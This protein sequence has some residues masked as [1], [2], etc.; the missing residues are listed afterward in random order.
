MPLW[1]RR[2]QIAP[3][4]PPPWF[5][6][7]PSLHPLALQVLYNR[8]MTAPETIQAFLAEDAALGNPLR[9]AGM[10]EAVFLI[11][12]AVMHGKPIAVYGDYDADGVTA[13]AILVQTLRTL[14]ADVRPYIP[15]RVEEGYGLNV[16]ALRALAEAGTR[17]LITVDCGIRSLEEVALARRLGLQVVITDHHH[18]G[19]ALPA[20]DVVLNPRRPDCPYPFKDLAGAGVAFKLAQA[21][22]RVNR[23]TPL[24][25]TQRDLREEELLDLA[26]LGTI[27]D[28]VPL[29]GENH[30]LARQGLR[31]INEGRRPGLVA[32]MQI[33]NVQPGKVTASTIGFTLAPR[34][35][36]AGRIGEASLAFD[37]LVAPDL[38]SALPLAQQLES[39]NRERQE[40]TTQVQEATRR[41]VLE[42]GDDPPLFFA[43]ADNFPS[44]IIGL[45]AGRLAEEFYR[46][47]VVV[48]RGEPLSKGSARSIPEFHI[49]EALDSMAELLE[50]YGGHAAAAGFTVRTA[51]LPELQAR[52]T[53]LAREQLAGVT[54]TPT[55]QIDAELPL[56]D[57]SWEL[58]HALA[59]L[60]PFGYGNP[61][62]VL[63][64]RKLR[65]LD[66]R[67]VGA[68]GRH[69]KLFVADGVERGR[70]WDA[71]AFR[72][73]DWI[74]RLPERIDL[75]YNLTLN[76]WN[77]RA[78]LQ[79][80]VHDIHPTE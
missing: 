6:R 4:A 69:L 57:L 75:A 33:A 58:Y 59:V 24:P 55:L 35:N 40:L 13:T 76:E 27:A 37:L 3:P 26:A 12:Q 41:M 78:N 64:S 46:P 48:E 9:M 73:G 71:I 52:L 2:W 1:R 42:S 53:A 45:A 47:V 29:L 50:R 39:L 79:L 34:L 15:D 19:A 32:L 22:L 17:L 11:R 54:L 66:A 49:T 8:G 36:A 7:H 14:G 10:H 44:G 43:A 56:G 25:T 65:V 23:Q 62:P 80:K 21:L 30:A 77:G 20:A 28:M 67:S 51:L 18:V 16:E 74:G 60:A 61:E 63:V 5:E 72:Q 31:E 38:S 68:D 70:G